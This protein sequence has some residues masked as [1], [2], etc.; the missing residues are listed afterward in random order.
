MLRIQKKLCIVLGIVAALS[1]IPQSASAATLAERKAQANQLA[2]QIVSLDATLSVITEEYQAAYARTE[3]LSMQVEQARHQLAL[4]EAELL[5]DQD[6]L[7]QRVADIYKSG[8]VNLIDVIVGAKTFD[9]FVSR[10]DFLSMIADMDAQNVRSVQQLKATI[11][12]TE[13]SL[14]AAR[15][16]QR[17]QLQI[18]EQKA[19]QIEEKLK[20]ERQLLARIKADIKKLA[21]E[22]LARRRAAAAAR[23]RAA[24]LAARGSTQVGA[25][26]VF[27]VAFPYSWSAND[28]HAPRVGHLHQ[29][30]DIFATIGTPLYSVVNGVIEKTRPV[31]S[32][33][34]GITVWVAGDDGNHYYYAHMNGIKPGIVPG[35]RVRAG[36][37]VGFV[38]KTGNARTTPAHLHFEIHPG[39]REATAINPI[40][41]LLQFR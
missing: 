9:Q 28:W 23:A 27:P 29:G 19:A 8:R 13:A 6:R 15:D 7:N 21:E 24:A 35:V 38:G 17:V 39:S 1:I 12:S 2:D 34:G 33:L 40:P 18:Q 14:V 30:T 31:E 26:F 10:I 22:E 37:V 11:A 16:E 20:E 5:V 36:D 32:G 3:Q 25:E 41:I 4:A